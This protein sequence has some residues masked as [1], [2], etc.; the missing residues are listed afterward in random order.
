MENESPITV[1]LALI[2]RL[3][4]EIV[5]PIYI[6]LHDMAYRVVSFYLGST[7]HTSWLLTLRVELFVCANVSMSAKT[8]SIQSHSR[9]SVFC[10]GSEFYL[11]PKTY[12]QCYAN[13]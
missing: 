9:G 3:G 12:Q 10:I 13:V 6:Y 8:R 4:S 11:N 5:L 7:A 1:L 2:A